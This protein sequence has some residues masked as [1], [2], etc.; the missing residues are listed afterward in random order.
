MIGSYAY[1][2]SNAAALWSIACAHET[3]SVSPEGKIF[4]NTNASLS[5]C[6]R[7]RGV[8][9]S[10]AKRLTIEIYTVVILLI[11]IV[12]IIIIPSPLPSF[13][14]GLENSFSANQSRRSLPF[15][16]QE[17]LRGFLT[18]FYRAM[19]CMRGICY[20]PLSVS[21]SV[22]LSVSQVGVLLKRL[23]IASHKQHRTQGL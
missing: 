19:L 10:C 5:I 13:I 8:E 15:L 23:N 21:L 7:V 16:L 12:I 6:C 11:F 14:P 20:G 22:C 18:Y 3:H 4:L 1:S 17:W 9:G 2:N